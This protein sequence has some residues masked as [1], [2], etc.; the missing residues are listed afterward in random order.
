MLFL[1][2]VTLIRNNILSITIAAIIAALSFM[3]PGNINRI[4]I[5][6]LHN[7]DKFIHALMYFTLT[8]TVFFENRKHLTRLINYLYLA[9]IPLV[10]GIS[11]EILQPLVTKGRSKETADMLFN[12]AG[13]LFAVVIRFL[14]SRK[15]QTS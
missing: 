1:L 8:F 7:A 13:I 2:P 9:M 12:L 3:S 10:F 6:H 14:I 5:L 11:I 4:N 15:R